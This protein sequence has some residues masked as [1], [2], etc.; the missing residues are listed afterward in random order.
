MKKIDEFVHMIDKSQLDT[1]D[2]SYFASLIAIDM[3]PG[4]ELLAVVRRHPEILTERIHGDTLTVFDYFYEKITRNKVSK[5]HLDVWLKN[6]EEII[7]KLTGPCSAAITNCKYYLLNLQSGH[8]DHTDMFKILFD[9]DFELGDPEKLIYM[10]IARGE[11]EKLKHVAEVYVI[12]DYISIFD[13]ALRFGRYDVIRFLLT[14]M[15]L[16]LEMFGKVLDFE[17]YEQ[18][19][20]KMD[21]DCVYYQKV[22]TDEALKPVKGSQDYILAM[23][24]VLRN[25]HYPVT[26]R[27]LELWCD[28]IREKRFPWDKVDYSVLSMIKDKIQESI[29][30]SHDFGRFNAIIFGQDSSDRS[31]LVEQNLILKERLF[32]LQMR[33]DTLFE[34]YNRLK[35]SLFENERKK[36]MGTRLR[37]D[38]S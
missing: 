35:E 36:F 20:D 14:D 3:G 29:P 22:E 10:L 25:Y 38:T 16:N 24:D 2:T 30:S 12:E 9:N 18:L 17:N 7:C 11:I 31:Q 19:K 8:L 5:E 23:E 15:D 6:F 27:T 33:Y 1:E 26:I 4:H 34:L 21:L 32:E 37:C 28:F 13:V